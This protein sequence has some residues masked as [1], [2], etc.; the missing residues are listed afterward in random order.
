MK[1]LYSI[2]LIAPLKHNQDKCFNAIIVSY[3]TFN[4]NAIKLIKYRMKL[5]R[6]FSNC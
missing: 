3:T 5:I 4:G 1:D 6:K 2:K